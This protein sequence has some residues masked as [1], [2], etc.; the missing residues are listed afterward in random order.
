MKKVLLVTLFLLPIFL[1]AQFLENKTLVDSFHQ[2]IGAEN[3][4][5]IRSMKLMDNSICVLMH[6]GNFIQY[7]NQFRYDSV[8][9][10]FY[11]ID[12][13]KIT[14]KKYALENYGYIEDFIQLPSGDILLAGEVDTSIAFIL[15]NQDGNYISTHTYSNVDSTNE[16]DNLYITNDNHVI[17]SSN[18]KI[19][20]SQELCG[21]FPYFSFPMDLFEMQTYLTKIDFSGNTI[22]H[23]QIAT[24]KRNG[25]ISNYSINNA[26]LDILNNADHSF[27]IIK[28]KKD[29]FNGDYK[30]ELLHIDKDG[31]LLNNTLLAE[32]FTENNCMSIFDNVSYKATSDGYFVF[33][34]NIE[35]NQFTRYHFNKAG[36][37]QDSAF[38]LN[39]TIGILPINPVEL[40]QFNKEVF[41]STFIHDFQYLEIATIMTSNQIQLTKLDSKYN[42]H[43]S[44]TIYDSSCTQIGNIGITSINDSTLLLISMVK[45]TSDQQ[46]DISRL[47]FYTISLNANVI[48]YSTYI[49]KNNNAQF[50]A[51]DTIFNA[52]RIEISSDSQTDIYPLDANGT[53]FKHFKTGTYISKL[54]SYEQNLRNFYVSPTADTTIFNSSN[55]IDSV[56]FRLVPIPNIQ[57]LQVYIIPTNIARPGF[58]SSYKVVA[59][60]VGSKT[61][62][63]IEVKFLKDTFQTVGEFNPTPTHISND[64]LI[65]TIDSLA[66]YENKSFYINCNNAAPPAL[67]INDTLTLFAS[68]TPTNNDTFID[69][70]TFE[71]K[72]II[73]NAYDPNDKTESHGAGISTQQVNNRD[74]LYYTIR[75]QNIGTSAATKIKI[76]DTLSQNLDW[77]TLELL[78]NSHDLQYSVKNK[79]II[80]WQND[81]VYLPDSASDEAHS[82][83]YV[84][85]RIK[86]IASLTTSDVIENRAH[87]YFDFNTAVIT[88]TV[89]T[90]IIEQRVSS[91]K[92]QT[93]KAIKLFPTP[94][95]NI[96]QLEFDMLLQRNLQLKVI[97]VNGN[98]LQ[99]QLLQTN[100]GLNNILIDVS[101]YANGIYFIQI[102]DASENRYYAKIVKQ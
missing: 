38:Q 26:L 30:L 74:Y 101:Q 100:T 33:R 88:N 36:I 15:L 98:E 16:I 8:A 63:N 21:V 11:T 53:L 43:W 35:N 49:D 59:Q 24:D 94:T 31:N 80:T 47:I 20:E 70:N 23:K 87:I 82:H 1:K 5:Y 64:T 54:I 14:T 17:M 95:S 83:G 37:L 60:N 3:T 102:N 29:D 61:I 92:Q 90:R 62:E 42:I 81:N 71:L 79:N 6:F 89:T 18:R 28:T 68:I 39:N 84:C 9:L 65:W 73:V 10:H 7:K 48:Y 78:S 75:F 44:E 93:I 19:I 13:S 40:L 57:D 66:I 85:F 27:N 96:V 32:N 99:S 50:D 25:D 46:E 41:K 34:K 4:S 56:F 51:T 86:P 52:A 91:I 69:D 2:N 77:S 58:Y 55:E 97:D 22:W 76:V 12:G 45:D 72:Q 67:N